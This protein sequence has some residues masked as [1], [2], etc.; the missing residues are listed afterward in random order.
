MVRK[1][2]IFGWAMYDFA[3]SGYTTVV[4]TAIFNAYFVAVVAKELESGTATFLWTVI[5]AF[6]NAIVLFASPIVGT[7]TDNTGNK[8]T[9]LFITMILCT[10]FTAL[11]YFV[12]S[13]DI[14]LASIL[15]ILSSVMFFIGESL[16]AAFLPQI[17]N[18]KNMGKISGFGWTL[19]YVGG[20][21]VLGISLAYVN[22]AQ[23][24]GELATDF[25][26][27]TMLIV[28]LS[29]FLSSLPTFFLLKD[30]AIN[31]NTSRGYDLTTYKTS[32]AQIQATWLLRHQYQ[33]FFR[34]LVCLVIIYC[35]INT[36]I[37][38]AAIYAQDVMAFTTEKTIQL[39]LIVNVMA[40]IGA[41][42]FSFIQDK[43]S[44]KKTLVIT[45]CIWIIAL[46]LA[47]FTQS[48]TWFWVVAM[49]IGLALGSSQSAGRTMIG[50]F[51]PKDRNGQFFG[52][53]GLAIRLSAII[54]PIFYGITAYL[55]QGNHRFALLTTT[56]F[57]IVGL[58]LLKNVN[59]DRGRQAARIVDAQ[60]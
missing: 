23:S 5:I 59:E 21:F 45:L 51:S 43:L 44:T 31:S 38:I 2:E 54:G 14:L 32:I 60:P 47:F 52:L 55:T 15:V 27:I 48:I 28:A 56:L 33:D 11:L 13:G 29:F 9:L 30:R 16:I 8:K 4:L 37:V 19:G 42:I 58:F 46:L 41:F 22:F 36:V 25:V 7:I 40:A 12:G 34:F 57:F 50:L 39:I 6:S 24:N 20:L 1:R 35:G 17:A 53:W 26:P 3:N 18:K 10:L 49:L